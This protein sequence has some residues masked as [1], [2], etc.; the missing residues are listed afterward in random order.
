MVRQQTSRNARKHSPGSCVVSLTRYRLLPLHAFHN[1]SGANPHGRFSGFLDGKYFWFSLVQENPSSSLWKVQ[2][3]RQIQWRMSSDTEPEPSLRR[4]SPGPPCMPS[5]Y[6]VQCMPVARTLP[7]RNGICSN[8]SGATVQ[9]LR[10]LMCSRKVGDNARRPEFGSQYTVWDSSWG[11]FRER[12]FTRTPAT[13]CSG[14]WR[15]KSRTVG[16]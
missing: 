8:I 5:I 16:L 1:F 6:L 10:F 9:L 15:K 2:Y 3:F 13:W 7:I 4:N 11:Q 12:W 14:L